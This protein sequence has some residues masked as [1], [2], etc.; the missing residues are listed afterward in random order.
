VTK[1]T[2]RTYNHGNA[3]G[4]NVAQ[5]IERRKPIRQAS[6]ESDVIV[7][8]LQSVV[9]GIVGAVI[10]GG[11]AAILD[12]PKPMLVSASIGGIALGIAW[13]VLLSQHRSLLWEIETVIG[14]DIDQDGEVG[15][16]EPETMTTVEIVDAR[17][18]AI[19]YVRL[20]LS[21][22]EIER[23]ALALLVQRVPLS[24][25]KL[26]DANAIDPE[27]YSDTLDKLLDGG[28]ARPRGKSRNA[29][30][31]LTGAGRAFFKQYLPQ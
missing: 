7:P 25:R 14:T 23:L 30:V 16:P 24:R 18:N 22:R 31:E 10:G 15:E 21:D 5:E 27:K 8:F 12:A 26:E 1:R 11:T 2:Y 20:P 6:L 3:T 9:T 13:L 28:L 29:G 4:A 17:R 19:N